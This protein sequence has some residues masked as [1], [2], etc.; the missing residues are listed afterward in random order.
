VAGDILAGVM[1]DLRYDG[2]RWQLLNPALIPAPIGSARGLLVKTNAGTP[3]SKVDIAATQIVLQSAGGASALLQGVA[4]TVDMAASGANGLDTGA[5][6]SG[7]WYYVWLIWNGT[8]LSGVFSV[9]GGSPTLPGGYTAANTYKAL[10]GA[11]RNDGGSNFVKFWQVD[12][13]VYQAEQNVITATAANAPATYENLS[14]AAFVPGIAR[15]VFGNAGS[16]NAT[17]SQ[18]IIAGDSNGVGACCIATP[19]S[20]VTTD[21]FLSGGGYR[22]P[23]MVTAQLTWQATD[24]TAH[25]RISVSGYTI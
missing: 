11:V 12:R 20:G 3:N 15:E 24:G 17:A 6:A 7:T 19:T 4:L 1:L 8:T 10:V 22:V 23:L 16:S 13:M 5:E 14:L 9:N 21:G 25:N 2:T 18:L